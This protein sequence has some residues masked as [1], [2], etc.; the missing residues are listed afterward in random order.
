MEQNTNEEHQFQVGDKVK[1]AITKGRYGRVV[2][3]SDARG[4]N[5]EF[6]Y[7]VQMNDGEVNKII[8]GLI[9]R[10]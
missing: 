3:L 8:E 2:G 9:N 7:D 5:G 6:L 4:E 10:T 1:H